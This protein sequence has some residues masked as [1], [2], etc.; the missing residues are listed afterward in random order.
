MKTKLK[1]TLVAALILLMSSGVAMALS[2]DYTIDLMGKK[3]A[4]QSFGSKKTHTFD[5]D[6]DLENG[7]I[8]SA[9]LSIKH[10]KGKNNF[11]GFYIGNEYFKLDQSKKKWQT[12]T[13][14]VT[15]AFTSGAPFSIVLAGK[16][17]NKKQKINLD[18]L[19]LNINYE[20]MAGVL[21]GSDPIGGDNGSPAP[22]PEPG[23][24]VLLGAGLLV[25]ARFG[26]KKLNGA[27]AAR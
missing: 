27:S 17:G 12:Q 15:D 24:L 13:F 5:F 20:D 8:S 11:W 1:I 6:N 7:A 26:F 4:F 2:T 23:T 22:V 25:V 14:D 18:W 10:K 9:T 3:K 21:P 16:K 19:A